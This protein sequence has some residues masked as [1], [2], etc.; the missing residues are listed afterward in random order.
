MKIGIPRAFLYYRYRSLWEAFFE[1]LGVEVVLS[2]PTNKAILTKGSMYAID[3][4]C[5]SSKIYLGH[6]LSL[7][8]RC[9]LIFVPR[10]SNFGNKDVLCT[11]FG[12]LF[13]VVSNTFRNQNIR[14]LDYNIDVRQSQSEMSAFFSLGK[15]LGKKKF[16]SAYAYVLAKQAEKL[17]Q[18]E[19][20]NRQNRLLE[21]EGVKLLIVGHSYNVYDALIGKPVL[22]YL[23]SMQVIPLIADVVDKKLAL[24][25]AQELT[26]SLP[27]I[28]NRELVGAVQEYRDKVDGIILLT[29]F[30]CGPDSLVNEIL[31]RRVKDLPILTLL[32]DGQEGTAGVETRLESFIDIIR[33]RQEARDDKA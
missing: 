12:A 19:E 15:K 4:A 25:K 8:D 33:F 5:L 28:Y 1:S 26:Y 32:L 24:E 9:D 2:G 7:I 6:V 20:L 22:D 21:K 23:K 14:L 13:D 16:Q 11:K 3:E 31:I 10:I 30:P 27:W 18:A 17:Q 29:T